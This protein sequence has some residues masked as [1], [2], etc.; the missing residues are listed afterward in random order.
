MKLSNLKSNYR[1]KPW[2]KLSKKLWDIQILASQEKR[3]RCSR[4]VG[5]N[6]WQEWPEQTYRHTQMFKPELDIHLISAWNYF[7]VLKMNWYYFYLYCM[8]LF[9]A[10]LTGLAKV[11]NR[12]RVLRFRWPLP[13]VVSMYS[14]VAYNSKAIYRVVAPLNIT[15]A[16]LR[17]KFP[18]FIT[19]PLSNNFR[20][21]HSAST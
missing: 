8:W 7:L 9:G 10:G 11:D 21:P 14:T 15:S 17:W 16:V 12:M 2:L 4:N 3:F 19:A 1:I 5:S 6:T 13:F 20:Q 18:Y